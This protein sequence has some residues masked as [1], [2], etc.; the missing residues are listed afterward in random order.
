MATVRLL[1]N[2][3]AGKTLQFE[4]DGGCCTF[5]RRKKKRIGKHCVMLMVKAVNHHLKKR[6][7]ETLFYL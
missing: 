4:L 1:I 6:D 5:E 7:A 2:P 3:L